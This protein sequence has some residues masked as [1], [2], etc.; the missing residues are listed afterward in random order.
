MK[1]YRY[2]DQMYSGVSIDAG[3]GENFYSIG[4]K[5]ELR[6][7]TITKETPCGFWI[8]EECGFLSTK[9]RWIS[10]TSRKKYACLSKEEGLKSFIRRKRRQC[11]ILST[12]L[13]RA[14]DALA[15]A[16]S[17]LNDLPPLP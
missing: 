15:N 16:T 2:Y 1:A 13:Q 5:I 11:S 12:Q 9:P 3:G 14:E 4:P 6:E 8:T 17:M 7:F 10:K